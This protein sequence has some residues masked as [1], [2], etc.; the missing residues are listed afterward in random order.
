MRGISE[1]NC[2]ERRKSNHDNLNYCTYNSRNNKELIY[3]L[4]NKQS[5]DELN[6]KSKIKVCIL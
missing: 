1:Y 5:I 2:H 4:H 6:P 3:I